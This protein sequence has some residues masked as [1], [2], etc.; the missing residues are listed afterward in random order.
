MLHENASEVG[1]PFD[2]ADPPVVSR[3]FVE[4]PSGHRIS[5][6]CWGDEPAEL[7]FLHGGAQNAHTWDTVA[8]ALGRPVVA[9]DLPGHGHSDWRDDKTYRPHD[10]AHDVAHTITALAP[11]ASTIV[12]MSLGG[13]T[14]LVALA[15]R[16]DLAERLVL[17]DITPG[18][19][20]HKAEPIL[21]FIAGPEVF[22][23]F[24]EILERTM[25][26]N[27]TRSRS[28]LR[29]G[30]LHN[31]RE[32]PDGTWAWRYDLPVPPSTQ[33]D[34]A[35]ADAVDPVMERFANLWEAVSALDHPLMLVQGATSGVVDDDD[36]AEL[37]RRRPDSTVIVVEGAGHSVQGDQPLELAALLTSFHAP[38]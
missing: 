34:G 4:A 17:V 15:D 22:A 33:G 16:S 30:V 21:S 20:Q 37:R 23:S 5:A 2:H 27:P 6:L 18:V 32:L 38:T 36:I 3:R 19:N 26:Y 29:R 35:P 28:S 7:V 8:L 9:I 31:A 24:D 13:L 11:T 25:A 1:L 12:G 10:M 14:G